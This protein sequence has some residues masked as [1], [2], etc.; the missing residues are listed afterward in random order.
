MGQ[1]SESTCL[2]RLCCGVWRSIAGGVVVRFFVSVIAIWFVFSLSFRIVLCRSC[3]CF[4]CGFPVGLRLFLVRHTDGGRCR[5]TASCP[6]LQII[7][8]VDRCCCCRVLS[9]VRNFGYVVP[10]VCVI[11]WPRSMAPTSSGMCR[12]RVWVWISARMGRC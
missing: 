5:E 8:L 12:F 2:T 4:G 10:S 1:R 11:S 9:C 6:N 3:C 7:L